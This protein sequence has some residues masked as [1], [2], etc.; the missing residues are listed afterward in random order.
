MAVPTP[1]TWTAEFVDVAEFNTELRDIFNF[2]LNPPRCY[3]YKS[4]D[5]SLANTTWDALNLTAEA[6]DSH[7][8]HDNS[9]NNTR[10][11]APETG[12]YG[13]TSHAQFDINSSGLRGLDIRMNA[14]GVQT[15]GT[16]LLLLI[17]AG[18]GTT[19]TRVAGYVERQLTA[20]DY[21]EAFVW[22]NSGGI[23]TVD[24]GQ[25]NTFLSFR[26]LAKT[27]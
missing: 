9:S 22:Q 10:L 16:D 23:L 4:A 2:L 1:K 7:S 24:G 20:G 19:E 27:V 26:W 15:G 11:V 8:A 6:Y 18:N 5:G 12:L 14:A 3:A 17:L 25:A 21:I 13:I